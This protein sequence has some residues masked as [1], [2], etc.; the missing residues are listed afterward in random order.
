MVFVLLLGAALWNGRS[1]HTRSNDPAP[2]A[3]SSSEAAS[4]RPPTEK[5]APVLGVLDEVPAK[6]DSAIAPPR[7]DSP[8]PRLPAP[9]DFERER[10]KIEQARRAHGTGTT[11][12]IGED[13]YELLSLRAIPKDAYLG[14]SAG[15]AF[16]RLGFVF[17]DRADATGLRLDGS[18][19][20]LSRR[21]NGMIAVVTGTF[22][23]TLKDFKAAGPVAASYGLG[24]KF[25]DESLRTAYFS[26]PPSAPLDD[27]VGALKADPS[28]E[29]VTLEVVQ[30]HKRF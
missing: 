28:I 3:T 29:S 14:S 10:Q 7:A 9:V 2:S 5:P 11:L 6:E 21:S 18:F 20:V 12:R 13:D 1:N 19:P 25:L 24:T 16:E 4:T 15:V 23:V 17:V 30:T 27:L 8:R 26:A 22:I